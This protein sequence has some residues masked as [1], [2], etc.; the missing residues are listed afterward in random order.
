MPIKTMLDK[1]RVSSFGRTLLWPFVQIVA[2]DHDLADDLACGQIAHQF[3]RACVAEGTGQRAADL[4]GYT[5]VP[6]PSSGM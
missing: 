2:R 6:R 5:S 1:R 3:L 4:R